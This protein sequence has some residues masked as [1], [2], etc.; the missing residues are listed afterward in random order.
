MVKVGKGKARRAMCHDEIRNTRD[1]HF[2]KYL[3]FFAKGSPV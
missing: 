3:T 1:E 2:D